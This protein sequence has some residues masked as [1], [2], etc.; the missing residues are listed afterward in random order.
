MKRTVPQRRKMD[1]HNVHSLSGD[2][3]AMIKSGRP[4]N[5][6]LSPQ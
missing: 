5:R 4:M 3:K 2:H 1:Y 6:G